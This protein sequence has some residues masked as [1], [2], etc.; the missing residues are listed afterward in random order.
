MLREHDAAVDEIA[1]LAGAERGR[2]RIG[3]ASAM[4][5]TDELPAILKELRKQHPRSERSL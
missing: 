2:I 5:L 1:E 4:V 3:S